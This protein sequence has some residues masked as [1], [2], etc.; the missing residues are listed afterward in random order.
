MHALPVG[1]LAQ[2]LQGQTHKRQLL[3]TAGSLAEKHFFL[4]RLHGLIRSVERAVCCNFAALLH[5]RDH[6]VLQLLFLPT[7][8]LFE[9][10]YYLGIMHHFF[11]CSSTP[12]NIVLVSPNWT[13]IS[14]EIIFLFKFFLISFRVPK[15]EHP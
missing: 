15:K 6:G 4:V 1:A 11:G 13:Q 3:M 7:E 12:Q 5:R 2:P 14:G 9:F 8:G 10:L